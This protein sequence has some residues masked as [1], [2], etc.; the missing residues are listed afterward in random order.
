MTLQL[1]HPHTPQEF[2]A[3]ARQLVRTGSD[4]ELLAFAEQYATQFSGQFTR[5]ELSE[6]DGLFEAAQMAVDL[7]EWGS[8]AQRSDSDTAAGPRDAEV[9]IQPATAR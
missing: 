1:P 6:M 2:L 9:P 5:E 8:R 7:E 3:A 4:R